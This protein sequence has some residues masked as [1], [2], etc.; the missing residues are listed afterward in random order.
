MTLEYRCPTVNA[1]LM[2]SA[3][4]GMIINSTPNDEDLHINSDHSGVSHELSD[5]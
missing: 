5:L 1:K 3:T 2:K 4:I